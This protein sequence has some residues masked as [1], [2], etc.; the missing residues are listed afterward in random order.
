MLRTLPARL[1]CYFAVMADAADP[2]PWWKII[3]ILIVVALVVGAG[4][5]ILGSVLGF[6]TTWVGVGVGAALGVVAA[7]LISRRRHKAP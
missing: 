7:T 2:M 1:S 3:A 4:V 6:S 5:G